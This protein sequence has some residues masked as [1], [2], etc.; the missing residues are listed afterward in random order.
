[1]RALRIVTM[2]LSVSSLVALAVVVPAWGQGVWTVP[3]D[4]KNRQNPAN[5]FASGARA[6]AV[7]CA[8]CHGAG[9]KGDGLQAGGLPT[10]PADWTSGTVQ[11]QT[12]G[13]LFWKISTGR[14]PMPPW[15]HLPEKDRWEVVNYIRT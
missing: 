4:A 1:M 2:V 12:D 15:K 7:N 14:G 9:G 11:K 6:V 13:E 3:P 5:G 10:K 8:M